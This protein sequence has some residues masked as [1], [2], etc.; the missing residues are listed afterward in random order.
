MGGSNKD[1][2]FDDANAGDGKNKINLGDVDSGCGGIH[3]V[4]DVYT[5]GG[6]LNDKKV[7]ILDEVKITR[8]LKEFSVIWHVESEKKNMS[9]TTY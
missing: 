3:D 5:N 8:Y 6:T 4:G 7:G 9:L 1:V 2:G